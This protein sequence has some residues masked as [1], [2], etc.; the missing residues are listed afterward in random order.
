M[1]PLVS[2]NCRFETERLDVAP[3]HEVAAVAELDLPEAVAEMLTARATAALPEAWRGDFSVERAAA[4]ID[5]RDYES[6]T[7]LVTEAESGSLAGLVM[8]ADVPLE[9]ARLEVRIGYVIAER[10]WSRGLATELVA[11]LVDWA[12]SQPSVQQLTGGVDSTNPASARVLLKNGFERIPDRKR[13]EAIYRLRI[14]G[15]DAVAR[16]KDRPLDR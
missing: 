6:P 3:W 13:G 14:D 12:R 16:D 9:E 5:E 8:L 2:T 10:F 11:G 7:L 15:A 1:N 4:W